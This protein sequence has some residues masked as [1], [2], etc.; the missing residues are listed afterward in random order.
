M[1]NNN[2][3]TNDDDQIV[4]G[5]DNGLIECREQMLPCNF[6]FRSSPPSSS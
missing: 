4:G 3:K 1:N 5:G 2:K 6:L